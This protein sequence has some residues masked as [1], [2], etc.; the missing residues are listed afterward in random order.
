MK[1]AGLHRVPIM[2]MT[3][4]LVTLLHNASAPSHRQQALLARG[5]HL[6]T[7]LLRR[8][9]RRADCPLQQSNCTSQS[10]CRTL[11]FRIGFVQF[12]KFL[13]A[14]HGS[15]LSCLWC[16]PSRFAGILASLNNSLSFILQAEVDSALPQNPTHH[17]RLCLM[18][19]NHL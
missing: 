15:A 13:Q 17:R 4:L 8:H 6:L 10:N 19:C 5:R 14:V 1:L 11:Y 9:F 12:C 18:S 2:A 7:C 3:A 16:C